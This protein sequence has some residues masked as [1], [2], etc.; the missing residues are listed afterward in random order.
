MTEVVSINNFK[1]GVSKTSSTAGIAYVLSEIKKKK[2]LVVDLDPQADVT[3]LL[4]KTFKE[5][6]NSLL[7]EVMNSDNIESILDEK[8]DEVLDLLLR[9]STDINENDLYHTLK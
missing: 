7:N 6:N 8:E 2:V 3:D 9:K 5:N 4:L 1:G